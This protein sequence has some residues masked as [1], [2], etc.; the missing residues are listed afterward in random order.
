MSGTMKLIVLV[1]YTTQPYEGSS[2]L[3]AIKNLIALVKQEPHYLN[4]ILHVDPI[5]PTHILLYEEWANEEYFKGDHLRT[6]HIQQ[7]IIDSRSFLAGP[8]EISFW[9]IVTT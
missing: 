8:P 7:F 3:A 5:D 2:A 4:I 1:K 6:Q 9:N